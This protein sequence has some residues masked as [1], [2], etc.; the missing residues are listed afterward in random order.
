MS[1][2]ALGAAHHS[3][4]A[5]ALE[6]VSCLSEISFSAVQNVADGP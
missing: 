5:I 1:V 2:A 3:N 4:S 6:D